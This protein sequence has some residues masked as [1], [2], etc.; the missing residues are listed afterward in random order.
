[1]AVA[2][3]VSQKRDGRVYTPRAVADALCRWAIR[4]PTDVVLDLG[5]G[6]G[7]FL[8]AAAHRLSELGAGADRV[9]E[10]IHGAE[11]DARV[12]A[13]AQALAREHLG[14]ALPHVVCGDF[15][16]TPLP[17]AQAVVGNPPYIRRHYQ[18]APDAHR[19]AAG[20]HAADRMT[21]A[22]CYFLFRAC[23]TLLPGGRLAAIISGSWLD[24]RYGEALKRLLLKGFSI[25]L[26]LGFEGRV[27]P[28]ALVKPVV[29]L[30]ERVL[31]T[32]PVRFARLGQGFDLGELSCA[33]EALGEGKPVGGAALASVPS[34]DLRPETAWSMFLKA[35]EAYSDLLACGA[36][37]PLRTLAESR[38]GLQTFAKPFYLLTRDEAARKGIEPEYLLPLAFSPRGVRGPALLDPRTTT[39]V[40]FACDRPLRDLEGTGAARHVADAM[41][42]QVRVR[43]TERTV[44]GYHQAP[45][46]VRSGRN[47]WYNVMREIDRRGTWPVLVPRRA[48]ASY[49][50]IHNLA[51]AVANEDFL[52]L[53][54]REASLVEPLLAVLNASVGEF[55]VRSHAFQYGGGVFNLNPGAL[56]DLPVPDLTCLAGARREALAQA[57]R[58]FVAGGGSPSVRA[59]LDD[60]VASALSLP[61]CLQVAIRAALADLVRSARQAVAPQGVEQLGFSA[62]MS[63]RLRS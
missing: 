44:H 61:W 49:L 42:T 30:A 7:A 21:D 28:N 9:K 8:L 20:A 38:I 23:A 3:D 35:P 32:E 1:M 4:A 55:L 45:R 11:V 18:P 14:E 53:R 25:R 56:R 40:V 60:A 54:P 41:Q 13:R 31:G 19:E 39:H 58:A 22:Y 46:L 51:G 36:W 6:E 33:L 17:A 27:F 52:E 57:W 34:A 59:A 26:V 50:V 10:A 12:F 43:G 16:V 5:V 15:Y 37:V 63:S 29:L 2:L 62:A 24:M 47:P 48:F